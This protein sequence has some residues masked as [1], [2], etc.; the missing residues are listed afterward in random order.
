M[1]SIIKQQL[2]NS[3]YYFL[4]LARLIKQ[5]N[6]PIYNLNTTDEAFYTT[7]FCNKIIYIKKQFSISKSS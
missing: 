7:I 6:T 3:H 1:E 4:S 5:T 2:L